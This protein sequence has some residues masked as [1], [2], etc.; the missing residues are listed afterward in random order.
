[1]KVNALR[2]VCVAGSLLALGISSVMGATASHANSPEPAQGQGHHSG[3][4]AKSR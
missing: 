4:N 2:I 1:M 3:L